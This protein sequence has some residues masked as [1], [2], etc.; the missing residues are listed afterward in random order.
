MFSNLIIPLASTAP[1]TEQTK[2]AFLWKVATEIF[3][4]QAD[5]GGGEGRE[6]RLLLIDCGSNSS[7]HTH[8]YTLMYPVRQAREREKAAASN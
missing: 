6:R 5:R 8:T 3:I 1:Q 4:N 7:W 2:F